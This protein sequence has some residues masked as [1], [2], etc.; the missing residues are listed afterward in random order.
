MLGWGF[1]FRVSC[2]DFRCLGGGDVMV[3]FVSVG[4]ENKEIWLKLTVWYQHCQHLPSLVLKRYFRHC[5]I[6]Y[7]GQQMRNPP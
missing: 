5:F 7:R 6:L 4:H 3:V 1:G 2:V